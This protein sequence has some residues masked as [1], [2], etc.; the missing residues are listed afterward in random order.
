MDEKPAGK[1][2]KVGVREGAG[3]PPGYQWNVDLLAQVHGESMG[4]LNEDQYAHLADQ[5]REVAR[6]EEPTQSPTVDVRPVEDF[7]EI[8]DKGGV[9]KKINARLFFCVC[10][11]T[12]TLCVVG[13]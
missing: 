1:A 12:R 13:A 3:P 11:S 2:V 10:H 5:V 6:H 8:R 4:F 7:F 9:L